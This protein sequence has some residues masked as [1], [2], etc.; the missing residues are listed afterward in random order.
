MV[1]VCKKYDIIGNIQLNTEITA[2]KWLDNEKL[3]ELSVDDLVPGTGDLG[4]EDRLNM[5]MSEGKESVVI[6][7]RVLKC[8]VLVSAVGG[9]VE[10]QRFPSGIP[11]KEEF[12]GPIIHSARWKHDVDFNNKRV[13]V[14]GSKS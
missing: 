14:I 7:S 9:L 4:Y 13:V 10:P 8:K 3:W 5:I 12:Q 11:G 1:Q 6:R 2:A